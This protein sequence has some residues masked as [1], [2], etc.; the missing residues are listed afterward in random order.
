MLHYHIGIP[1]PGRHASGLSSAPGPCLRRDASHRLPAR[2]R[3]RSPTAHALQVYLVGWIFHGCG[4]FRR[5]KKDDQVRWHWSV[6]HKTNL[7]AG[8][9]F[10]FPDP[11]YLAAANEALSAIGI[12][13]AD[14]CLRVLQM[15]GLLVVKQPPPEQAPPTRMKKPTSVWKKILND[16]KDAVRSAFG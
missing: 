7:T 9:P 1:H 10:G 5:E 16:H 11:D 12:P 8:G 6:P 13:D 2:F 14:A 15:N 3:P 4:L